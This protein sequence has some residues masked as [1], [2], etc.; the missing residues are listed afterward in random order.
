MFTWEMWGAG[1]SEDVCSL[2]KCGGA[3]CSEDVCSHVK[4]GVQ[5]TVRMCVHMVNVGCRP[6]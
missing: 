4:C 6:Q 5:A 1:H 3:C 2:G